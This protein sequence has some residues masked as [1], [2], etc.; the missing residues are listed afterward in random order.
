MQALDQL[1]DVLGH[2]LLVVLLIS[3]LWRQL[4]TCV[5]FTGYVAALFGSNL[6]MSVLPDVFYTPD[7]WLLSEAL[8]ALLT[9]AV[10]VELGARVFRSFPGAHRTARWAALAVV[11]AG[12]LI[13]LGGM[14]VAPDFLATCE[15]VLPRVAGANLWLFLALTALILWYRVPIRPFEKAII[16]GYVPFLL[17]FAASLSAWAST[18]GTLTALTLGYRVTFLLMAAY[19]SVAAWRSDEEPGGP[20]LAGPGVT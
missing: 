4:A 5:S 18:Q 16:L 13:T 8:H 9:F 15:R 12:A 14:S 19:W 6:L 7:A 2:V 11:G 1:I 10:A 3:V 20:A 17:V